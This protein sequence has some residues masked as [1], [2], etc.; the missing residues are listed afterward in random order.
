[1]YLKR[2]EIQGF[3]SFASRTVLEFGKGITAVVGPN[4]SGKS[5]IADSIRWVLG[6][7]SLKQ[8]RGK[9]SEDVIFAGSEKKSRMSFAEVS[10]TFD[11]EDRRIP[12]DYSEVSITRRIDRSGESEYL[13]NGNKVRLL[14]IVDLVLKS[15]IGTSRYTVI[16]QGTIDQMILAGPAEIK[17]LLDEASGV[18]TYY[19]RRERTLRRLEQSAQNLM[20]VKDLLSEIEPRLKSLRRQAKKME[21]RENIEKELGDCQKEF[22]SGK[23][24]QLGLLLSDADAK[25]GAFASEREGLQEEIEKSRALID[26]TENDNQEEIRAYR[27]IQEEIKKLNEKKNKL[28][29]DISLIRGKLAAGAPV[30]GDSGNFELEKNN[31]EA[32]K[33]RL[34]SE[35]SKA[36]NEAQ[37][38]QARH[39]R[40][41]ELFS[42]A[43]AKLSEI[44][45][46]L[47]NPE[48]VNFGE[49]A[50]DV[51]ELDRKFGEFYES[52]KESAN[53]LQITVR[54]EK[55]KHELGNFR[56]KTIKF[57]Q[58]PLLNFG[59]QRKAL[60][61]ILIKKDE[62][63]QELN[64][65]DLQKSK[66][67]MHLD[68][69][70]KE[71]SKAEARLLQVNL[72]L[73]RT[74]SKTVDE[75]HR[76]LLGREQNLN[77]EI[78]DL[79]AEISTLENK[80]SEYHSAE[81]GRKAGFLQTERDLRQKQD[82]L[83]KV[84]DRE[85]AIQVEKAKIETQLETVSAEAARFLGREVAAQLKSS[86]AF[87][88]RGGLED[89]IQKL[90]KTL[91]TIG[92]IDEL[93]V[94]EYQ[95]TETRYSYLS[96]QVEDLQKAMDDLRK[97]IEE[98]DAQIKKIFNRSFDGINEKFQNYFRILF[99]GG[100]AYLN[101]IKSQPEKNSETAA[102]ENEDSADGESAGGASGGAEALRPEEKIIKKYEHGADD[103]IGI[104][105]KAT[106]PGKK[107]S[108]I[109]ALSGGER[110][111]TSIALLC[112]LL[113]CFP[114]P[115]VMLDEV[116]AALDEANTIRF[117]QILGTLSSG[118]QFITVTHNRETMREANILYGVTMGDDSV[119]K[120]LSLRIDQAQAYAK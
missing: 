2:L 68:Y 63:A 55:F 89:R 43:S 94:K 62:I 81:Q 57:A 50:E 64:R 86:P 87:S 14:D 20:R 36:K 111:L 102:E 70:E 116:D 65:L 85:A 28:I 110:S 10:V 60:Q 44:Q 12:L 119:S 33:E 47:D 61:E 4:G 77:K 11:N 90:Q 23:Y 91:E 18:K 117:A 26:K 40:H 82:M 59:K 71:F 80:I 78:L 107:L 101:V 120:L 79:Q 54:A 48:A 35:I 9:K 56:Q 76:D 96:G 109:S 88:A 24:F 52:I 58:N 106:P 83:S 17:N 1:M 49:L 3:K 51:N 100:R 104:D 114:S 92:G 53:V 8:L 41:K 29:E 6:E 115:F 98:L 27:Q 99:N 30:G 32:G 34:S 108:S 105:I 75:Y 103:I 25:L 15:N 73:R 72:E 38:L 69:L 39:A 113:S 93:T 118:T 19:I 67:S 7:Q 5:N 97:V 42:Q 66:I 31:L 46:L 95:E 45:I 37:D 22:Y 112:A 13:I 74:S 16:S 21:E 84:K